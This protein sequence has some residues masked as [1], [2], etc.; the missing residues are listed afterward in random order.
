MEIIIFC[1]EGTCYDCKLQKQV[2]RRKR[3]YKEQ[4]RM[5]M[6]YIN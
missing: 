6:R 5:G 1:R 3:E 2:L 4:K